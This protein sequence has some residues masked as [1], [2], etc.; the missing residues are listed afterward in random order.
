MGSCFSVV[1]VWYRNHRCFEGKQP[2]VIFSALFITLA[3]FSVKDDIKEVERGI[4]FIL[5]VNWP[6]D[7]ETGCELIS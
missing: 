5:A 2:G 6:S 4:H 1:T 3:R 7:L